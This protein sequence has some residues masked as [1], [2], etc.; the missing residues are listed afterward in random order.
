LVEQNDSIEF[1]KLD[2][3]RQTKYADDTSSKLNYCTL[4]KKLMERDYN[5]V[6]KELDSLLKHTTNTQTTNA[7]DNGEINNDLPVSHKEAVIELNVPQTEASK[8][9]G[10][11]VHNKIELDT[12]NYDHE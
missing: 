2:S 12:K 4:Q 11:K 7:R 9:L 10:A 8:K 3:I 6:K 5:K 1:W